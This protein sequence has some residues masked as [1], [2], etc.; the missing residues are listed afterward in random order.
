MVHV[1]PITF[2]VRLF[3]KGKVWGDPF[4]GVCTVQKTGSVGFVSAYHGKLNKAGTVQLLEEL[5]QYGITELK[6]VRG[7]N[8]G[9][10]PHN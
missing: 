5:E 2:T 10:R 1:E 7:N 8:S 6:W 3:L 9:Q 4:D